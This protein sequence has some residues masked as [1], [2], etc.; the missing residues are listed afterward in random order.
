MQVHPASHYAD[1]LL[2]LLIDQL[3]ELTNTRTCSHCLQSFGR[4]SQFLLVTNPSQSLEAHD[5][6]HRTCKGNC[7]FIHHTEWF[8]SVQMEFPRFIEEWWT[9]F[10]DVNCL[11]FYIARRHKVRIYSLSNCPI[12][13]RHNNSIVPVPH[14]NVCHASRSA[15]ILSSYREHYL[16]WSFFQT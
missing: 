13:V 8:C 10:T 5:P 3:H 6:V 9:M 12:N 2:S 16:I 1:N 7:S 11:L 4:V 14:I 15:L